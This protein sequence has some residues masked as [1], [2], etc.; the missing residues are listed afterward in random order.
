MAPKDEYGSEFYAH[1]ICQI[2]INTNSKL[3]IQWKHQIEQRMA[4]VPNKQSKP[5]RQ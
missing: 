1:F 5:I 4:E 2:P 3:C